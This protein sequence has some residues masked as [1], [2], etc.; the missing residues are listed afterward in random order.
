MSSFKTKDYNKPKP[1]KV[2]YGGGKKLSKPKPENPFLL[3][4]KKKEL[5]DKIIRDIWT[6]FETEGKKKRKKE[7]R[8]KR[9]N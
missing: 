5:K 6:L 2:V 8:E 7:I 3:K 9:R 1:T 4:K